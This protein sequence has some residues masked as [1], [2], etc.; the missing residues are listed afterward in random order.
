MEIICYSYNN[1]NLFLLQLT[2][3]ICIMKLHQIPSSIIY[4]FQHNWQ[5]LIA[6][7]VRWRFLTH[8][9][10]WHT[11][12]FI[13]RVPAKPFK[14]FYFA[15]LCLKFN[16]V[17]WKKFGPYHPSNSFIISPLS[18][19]TDN[20]LAWLGN[21]P[22]ISHMCWNQT[23]RRAMDVLLC[24]NDDYHNSIY[25]KRY[26]NHCKKRWPVMHR[27]SSRQQVGKW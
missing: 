5:C 14:C 15:A 19:V 22:T 23:A 3:F 8:T 21:L 4:K 11:L 24:P 18:L 16:W 12:H 13:F 9:W 17:I 10:P 27:Q 1:Y 7:Y 20:K 26:P 2:A 6:Y 25:L